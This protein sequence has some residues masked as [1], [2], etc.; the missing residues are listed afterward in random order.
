MAHPARHCH[1]GRGGLVERFRRSATVQPR[2]TGAACQSRRP[3]RRRADGGSARDRTGFARL[4]VALAR[5][6]CR[7]RRAVCP[8]GTARETLVAQP[9]FRASYEIDLF[10]KNAARVDAARAGVAASAASEGTVRLSVT[11]ATASGYITLLALDK[12][13]AVLE[14]T[15]E[16]RGEAL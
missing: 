1:P 3:G 9:A 6:R 12:Q 11:A 2:R 5:R 4:P 7:R 16:A 15:L 8:L 14:A 10:G 13:L